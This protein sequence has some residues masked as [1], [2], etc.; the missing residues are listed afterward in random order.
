V[1]L[2]YVFRGRSSAS[3]Q[4]FE[5]L[6]PQRRNKFVRGAFH[7][8]AC[9]KRLVGDYGVGFTVTE[10]EAERL[11]VTAQNFVEQLKNYLKKWIEE[12]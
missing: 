8:D 11:L 2:R 10:N 5:C 9:D 7:K 3:Y 12:A 4:E 1:L 6:L